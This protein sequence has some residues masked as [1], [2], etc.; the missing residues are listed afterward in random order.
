MNKKLSIAVLIISVVFMSTV[1]S[2]GRKGKPAPGVGLDPSEIV[3]H[4][5][6]LPADYE[7]GDEDPSKELRFQFHGFLRV[8]FRLGYGNG[9]DLD[10]D[11]DSKLRWHV[12]PQIPDSSYVDWRFTNNMGGPGTELRLIY[13]NDQPEFVC[14]V[15][16]APASLA[17]SLV[18]I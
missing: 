3:L 13:G 2:A 4:D 16:I 1:A 18:T 5:V 6:V 17:R 10:G 7:P 15:S 12:P 14:K 8:P 9:E 11:G